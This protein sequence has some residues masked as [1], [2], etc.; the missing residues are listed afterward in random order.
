MPIADIEQE[1]RIKNIKEVCYMN[2]YSIFTLIGGLAF[3]LYGIS[4]MSQGLENIAGGKLEKLLKKIT[5]NPIKSFFI[6]AG[7]TAIIQSSSA[8]TVILIGLVNSGLMSLSQTI[9]IIFGANVGTTITAWLLSLTAIQENAGTIL[10]ILKPETFSPILAFVGVCFIMSSKHAKQKNIGSVMIGFS[11]LMTGMVFMANAM[12]PLS[13]LPQFRNIMLAFTNPVLG[14]FAGIIITML[15]QS[16]SASVGILQALS[17]SGSVSWSAAIPIILGQ[18]IGTCVSAL[19]AGIGVST[20]ARRVAAVHIIFN[21]MGAFIWFGLYIILNA[22]FHFKFVSNNISPFGIALFHTIYNILTAIVL[23]PFMKFIERLATKYVVDDNYN[24]T[25]F[26]DERL[27]L[28]P[29][30]AISECIQ[31]TTEMAKTTHFNFINSLKMLKT[32]RSRMAEE[33]IENETKL[34]LYEDKLNS[35]LIKLSSKELSQK[36]GSRISQLLLII[37]E[38]EKIADHAMSILKIAQKLDNSDKKFSNDADMELYTITKAVGEIFYIAF[39]AYKN[40]DLKAA[41][42]VESLEAVIKKGIRRARNNHI[43]RLKEN[44]CCVEN[45]FLFSDILIDLRRIAAHCSNIA[46]SI[47]QLYDSDF[48]KHKFN[49]RDKKQDLEFQKKYQNYKSI[50]KVQKNKTN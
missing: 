7:I 26:L 49:H 41:G 37:S 11:I 42:K 40:D 27:L 1:K 4:I 15:I 36:D 23:F 6:G 13:E 14:L 2:I 20:N 44:L 24:K 34:D 28:T 18:N 46:F 9:S 16:S 8:V 35:F 32:Y 5:S 31:K 22:I 47:I 29:A 39:E 25:V 3:F 30:F 43:Q 38:F 33:I 45:G 48:N 10:K 17:L 12:S 21:T 19:L 50:Y